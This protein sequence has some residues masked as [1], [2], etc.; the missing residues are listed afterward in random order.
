MFDAPK[1]S[2][3]KS[4][5][6]VVESTQDGSWAPRDWP[7]LGEPE[8]LPPTADNNADLKIRFRLASSANNEKGRIDDVEVT[9]TPN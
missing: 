5:W 3:P 4:S 2:T 6:N 8:Q 9:A 1:N 7:L